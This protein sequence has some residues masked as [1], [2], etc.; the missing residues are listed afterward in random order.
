ME[1]IHKV[2]LRDNPDLPYGGIEYRGQTLDQFMNDHYDSTPSFNRLNHDLVESGI[3]EVTKLQYQYEVLCRERDESGLKT[4]DKIVCQGIIAYP[5]KSNDFFIDPD[6]G[7]ITEFVDTHGRYHSW[8]SSIDGGF[9]VFN[10]ESV[11]STKEKLE[12][13]V[14]FEELSRYWG[15][16]EPHYEYTYKEFQRE[17]IEGIVPIAYDYTP[18][19]DTD[20]MV[21]LDAYDY[22]IR[23]DIPKELRQ[24]GEKPRMV[25]RQYDSIEQLADS[26][27]KETFRSLM[28][29][30]RDAI[31]DLREARQYEQGLQ[32]EL[33]IQ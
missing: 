14:L 8:H 31:D 7:I 27:H 13:K 20:I 5:T 25:M 18:D 19:G 22:S 30:G 11:I 23:V 12:Q 10:E 17:M 29:E 2:Y 1:R 16:E 4:G 6:E 21:T 28:K 3:K 15:A 32:A 26:L 33:C 24:E 9:V